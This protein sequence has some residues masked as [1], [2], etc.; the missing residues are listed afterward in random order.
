MNAY[1][2]CALNV[3]VLGHYRRDCRVFI[4]E[5]SV[6]RFWCGPWIQ[7]ESMAKSSIIWMMSKEEFLLEEDENAILKILMDQ[8]SGSSCRMEGPSGSKAGEGSEHP[9]NMDLEC[10][11][12]Q[13]QSAEH[14]SGIGGCLDNHVGCYVPPKVNC[15]F[16]NCD[17]FT[18]KSA[19]SGKL[20]VKMADHAEVAGH[21]ENMHRDNMMGNFH[22]G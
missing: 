12:F 18:C 5:S 20:K 21:V 9:R 6:D 1:I 14:Q 3:A 10:V 16:L 15:Q 2:V 7:V 22:M 17:L 11:A 4:L 8:G 13:Q 19:D